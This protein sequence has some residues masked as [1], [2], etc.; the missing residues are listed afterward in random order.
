MKTILKFLESNKST[1]TNPFSKLRTEVTK[2]RYEANDN[3]IFLS[4]LKE[5]FEKLEDPSFEFT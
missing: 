4:T 2:A 3:N 5:N 1:Y